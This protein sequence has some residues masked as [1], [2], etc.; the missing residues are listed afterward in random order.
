MNIYDWGSEVDDNA[1]GETRVQF[2]SAI[3]TQVT[4]TVTDGSGWYGILDVP[5][6]S[7]TVHFAKV[8][9][10][11]RLIP[12]SIPVAGNI[13]TVNADMDVPVSVSQL[14]PNRARRRH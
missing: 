8:G 2:Y 13:I 12:A 7:H 10:R 5:V 1:I 6:G 9:L 3:N 14:W 11:D 4:A